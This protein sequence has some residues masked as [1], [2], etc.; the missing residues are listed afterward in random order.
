MVEG[1]NVMVLAAAVFV[2]AAVGEHGEETPNE[3]VDEVFCQSHAV[4]LPLFEPLG[5]VFVEGAKEVEGGW[6]SAR[7]FGR[8]VDYARGRSL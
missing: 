8:E 6:S 1:A 5:G 2:E 3:A 4:L 7:T